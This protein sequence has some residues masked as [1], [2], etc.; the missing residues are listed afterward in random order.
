MGI[1]GVTDSITFVMDR[2]SSEFKKLTN[3]TLKTKVGITV[4][5]FGALKTL[6]VRGEI[7]QQELANT[8]LRER[9]STKKL[10]DSCIRKNMVEKQDSPTNKKSAL[11]VITSL[12]RDVVAEAETILKAI[13]Q[14]LY[15]D[16]SSDELAVVRKVCDKLLNH[17]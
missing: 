1:N 3:A 15:R 8:L 11:L 7:N 14:K 10:V 16:I 5:E 17:K 12:G 4:E 9:S 2:A 6:C 13:N